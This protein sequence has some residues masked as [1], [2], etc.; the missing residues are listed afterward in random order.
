MTET[1]SKSAKR[2]ALFIPSLRGGGAERVM[3]ALATG[4]AE[5]HTCVDLVVADGKGPFRAGISPQ[6]RVVDLDVSRVS[7]AIPG[8]VRYLVGSK[9]AAV[10]S[11]LSHANVICS[12]AHALAR[13][14]S[15][16]VLSE[17]N[18]LSAVERA[19]TS[20][21]QRVVRRTMNAAYRRANH[22]VGVSRGVS[23]DLERELELK[24]GA[25]RTIYNP[26]VGAEL[27]R[28][29]AQPSPHQWLI[30]PQAPVFLGVGRLTEQKKF[31][32]LIDAFARVRSS[33]LARLVI[34]GEGE[35]RPALE[36]QI[37]RL[38]LQEDV[39]MPGFTTNPFAWMAYASVFVLS[40]AWEGLP[41]VLI[42][43]M[44]C[45]SSVV[46]TDCPSGPKEI[47]EDGR[48]GQLVPVGDV[49]ALAAAMHAA[50]L[51][52]ARPDV[53]ARAMDFTVQKAV[54]E[55]ANLMRHSA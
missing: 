22:L 54:S 47:L 1:T 45:G 11:A 30:D 21:R 23:A 6:I 19:G 48:W 53:R 15:V 8:L 41:T 13:S 52:T 49:P 31:D 24:E 25:V 7:L 18:T 33:L 10:L 17:H 3:L 39:L 46:S 55:Y 36:A 9:P 32:H 44:A 37:V 5:L 51:N 14:R 20:L 35:L 34:L 2:I 27:Q 4:L 12:L 29:K 50:L 26:V 40:S 43:A 42:E 16:L 28:L 38:G